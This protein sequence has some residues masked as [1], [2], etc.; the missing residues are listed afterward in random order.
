MSFFERLCDVVVS[1]LVR[2]R[3]QGDDEMK[4]EIVEGLSLML[5]RAIALV[6][7]ADPGA[8]DALMAGCENL[9]AIEVTEHCQII[10][11]IQ[12]LVAAA[13]ANG[14]SHA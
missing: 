5:A 10:R 11:A 6:G 13:K 4:A 9:I 14:D 7:E 12:G 3:E 1:D 8:V 2:A